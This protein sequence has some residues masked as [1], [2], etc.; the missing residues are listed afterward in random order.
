MRIKYDDYNI[1]KSDHKKCD[2]A[3]KGIGFGIFTFG[4]AS[5]VVLIVKKIMKKKN[6]A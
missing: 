3:S 2:N 1:D 6:D 4:I 5:T